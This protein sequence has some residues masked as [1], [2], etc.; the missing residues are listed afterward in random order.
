MNTLKI[1][2]E[3]GTKYVFYVAAYKLYVDATTKTGA[4]HTFRVH[5]IDD[6]MINVG[7][8][9]LPVHGQK[10]DIIE[11]MKNANTRKLVCFDTHKEV[12]NFVR[13]ANEN[14]GS[15]FERDDKHCVYVYNK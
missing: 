3:N 11:F 13:T 8:I 5:S 15:A 10:D 4:Q 9:C 7:K 6:N 1:Q 2:N 12:I 14:T